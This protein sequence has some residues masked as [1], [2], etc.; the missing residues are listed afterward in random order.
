LGIGDEVLSMLGMTGVGRREER[1][2]SCERRVRI[3]ASHHSGGAADSRVT[4]RWGSDV[5]IDL[6]AMASW[7]LNVVLAPLASPDPT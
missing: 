6:P 7:V 5:D 4:D 1:K 3:I 2:K